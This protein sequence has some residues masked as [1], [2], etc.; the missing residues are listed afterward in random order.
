[1]NI[2]YVQSIFAP[3]VNMLLRFVRSVSSFIDYYVKNDYKF[4]C[5]FGGY[6]AKEEYWLI[7][8]E[9]LKSVIDNYHIDIIVNRFDKNYGKA[10]VVNSL[11]EKFLT[12]EEYIF[13]ADSDICY[14]EN[15]PNIIYRLVE[16][17]N[18]SKAINLNPSLISLY[19]E[20]ANCHILNACYE[21]RHYYNGKYGSEMVC[22][23]TNA[24]G[25]AG[26]CLFISTNFWKIVN[27]YKVLGVYAA[28]DANIMI[29]SR[30]NGYNFLMSNSIRCIHPKETDKKY[31]DWKIKTS[32]KIQSLPDA[33]KDA[34]LFW[35]K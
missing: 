1:M 21:N 27:G 23:P 15:Q 31:Q 7:I 32:S 35:D 18:Y 8:D 30:K 2:I 33:I 10:Y 20:E 22:H 26:G 19:Q 29:D 6:C 5:V 12:N 14:I 28:D 3:N 24:G 9:L 4:K 25:V 16:A 17:M 13:T 11:V 34:N